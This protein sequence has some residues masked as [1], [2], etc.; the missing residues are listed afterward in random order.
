MKDFTEQDQRITKEL[1][2]YRLAP[3]S[4]DLHERVLL[5]AREAWRTEKRS[6]IG[7]I[8]G[9]ERVGQFQQEILALASALM[10]ILGV[11]MQL[12]GSQSVLADSMERL[13]RHGCRIR[14]PASR[15]IHGL[16]RDEAGRW[17]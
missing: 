5:A 1:D 14:E 11:V 13:A 9:R 15:N 7:P 2:R 6:C 8:A 16:H 4:P 3:P 17:G 12:G 10:L